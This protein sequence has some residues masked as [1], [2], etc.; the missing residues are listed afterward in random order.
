VSAP[1]G[2]LARIER[3]VTNSLLTILTARLH[4]LQYIRVNQEFDALKGLLELAQ[5][6]FNSS[7]VV[8]QLAD[9][10]NR[11]DS[12]S[13]ADACARLSDLKNRQADLDLRHALLDRLGVVALPGR[14]ASLVEMEFMAEAKSR[15]T[16]SVP[17]F[18]VN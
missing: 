15:A 17:G 8:A 3:A 16:P 1:Y 14:P 18:G 12:S 10:A 2:E 11:L 7:P 5:Q 6:R 13:Y 9:A 4:K